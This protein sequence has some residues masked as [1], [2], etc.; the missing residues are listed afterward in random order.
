MNTRRKIKI[1]DEEKKYRSMRRIS[2][3]KWRKSKIIKIKLRNCKL[4]SRKLSIKSKSYKKSMSLLFRREIFWERSLF[5]E[6]RKLIY[7]MKN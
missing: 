1:E 5:E 7:S 3:I 2:L 6:V 4:S